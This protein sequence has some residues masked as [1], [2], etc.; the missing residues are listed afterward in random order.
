M[1]HFNALLVS[2]HEEG[3]PYTSRCGRAAIASS[4]KLIVCSKC[5]AQRGSLS[6]SA[7]SSVEWS[8]ERMRVESVAF[9]PCSVRRPSWNV[10][11]ALLSAAFC[12][13]W[14]NVFPQVVLHHL[15]F[16][17][18]NLSGLLVLWLLLWTCLHIEVELA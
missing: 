16:L 8:D 4:E 1:F 9:D 17:L 13:I 12:R 7:V 2:V 10:F 14:G 18:N 6:F 5:S 11:M 3:L 15:E